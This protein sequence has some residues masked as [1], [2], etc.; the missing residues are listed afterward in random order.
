MVVDENS[1]E[2]EIK[3]CNEVLVSIIGRKLDRNEAFIEKLRVNR[4][5]QT[6]KAWRKINAQIQKEINHG[7]IKPEEISERIDELILKM[8]DRDT[9]I[10]PEQ[11]K[12]N[13]IS[14][15]K[16]K[17]LESE[18]CLVQIPF[19]NN[20]YITSLKIAKLAGSDWEKENLTVHETSFEVNLA[21]R[22]I[23]FEDILKF[24]CLEKDFFNTLVQV[25]IEDDEPFIFKAENNIVISLK[26]IIN[27]S[28]K[29]LD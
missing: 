2:L 9:V 29:N 26:S 6:S 16:S 18:H 23:N 10:T 14:H 12:N 27:D 15:V 8:S 13:N 21:E 19:N 25:T 4:V 11:A 5:F 3:K 28:N 7:V 20:V 24:E 1:S 17:I 22:V